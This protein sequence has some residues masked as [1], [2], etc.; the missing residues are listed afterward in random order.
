MEGILCIE[1]RTI[2]EYLSFQV[3]LF[4]FFQQG[5]LYFGYIAELSLFQLLIVLMRLLLTRCLSNS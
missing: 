2:T 4:F 3:I 1:A 5:E